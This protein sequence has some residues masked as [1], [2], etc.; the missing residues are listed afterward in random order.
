MSEYASD[1]WRR[2]CR[3]LATASRNIEAADP[4]A[5]ASR[6]YYAAFYAVSALFAL[7]SRDFAKHSAVEAAVHRELVRTGR[8]PPE[9]GENYRS[10]R[11]LRATGDY[12]HLD[13]VT[14]KAAQDAVDMARRI[15]EAVQQ[16]CPE[17]IDLTDKP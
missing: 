7:E 11:D 9:L 6:A 4:D 1:L 8:W 3:A 5:A 12:G 14:P 15:L 10:L 13:H 2:A 17:L 16:A